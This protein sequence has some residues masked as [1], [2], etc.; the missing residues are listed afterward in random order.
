MKKS[1]IIKEM[2]S[3]IKRN[4]IPERSNEE[5]S[6][7]A[8]ELIEKMT[9]GEKLG[10][11]YET[12]YTG[13]DITGPEFNTD[14]VLNSIREGKV[15]SLLG[16]NDNVDMYI[17]QK[18]A[19]E[20]SRLGI[21]MFFANDI[22]HGC[23]TSYPVNLALASSF[24]MSLIKESYKNIAYE[25]SHSG[26][27]LT[28]APMLD[29]A[30]D[31]RWG[32]VMEGY[33]EDT[34]LGSCV[35]KAVVE[36]LQQNDLTSYDTVASCAKHFVGYAACE[37]GR[38]YNT[39]DF[40]ERMLKQYYLPPFKSAI[41]S[42]VTSIM[43]AFNIYDGIPATQNKYLL[44]KVLRDELGF[45]G[46]TISDYTSTDETI[47]HKTNKDKRSVA[48]SCMKAGLNHEMISTT[49]IDE[50][51]K[52]IE[53]GEIELEL[54]DEAVLKVLEF[55]FKIG[56]FDNPYKNI[57]HNQEDYQLNEEI[58]NHSREAS[59]RSITLLKNHN[60][61]L[62]IKNKDLKIAVIGPMGDSNEVVGPWGGRARNEDCVSLLDG[63][64][65]KNLNNISFAK[66]CKSV[67]EG[68]ESLL[69][70]AI[71]VAN[72]SDLV[73]LALGESQ[74]MS[75]EAK[76]R[77]SILIPKPQLELAN[78]IKK[79]GKKTVLVSFSGRPLDL[80][81]FDENVDGI[82]HSWF[83]GTTS[84]DAL[85]D[86]IFGDYN[87]SA[88]VSMSFPRNVGQVPIYY[89]GFKTGRPYPM[90]PN[91]VYFSNYIDS[92]NTPL[93]PFGFGLSYT[94]FEISNFE[95][96]KQELKVNEELTVKLTVKNTG[97]VKGEEVVQL[98]IEALT[99]SVT[100]P[101]NELKAFVKVCLEP[102]EEQ[103]VV[104]K[105]TTKDLAYYNEDMEFT[106][107]KTDY[108]I[109]VGNASNNLVEKLIKTV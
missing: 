100:R 54:V 102:K 15:G 3:A 41:D 51:P 76:S 14:N 34:Y 16:L 28:F 63:L 73:I 82:L 8:L 31:P 79:L 86:V 108:A 83:L 66:G 26:V 97:L 94:T 2:Q 85:A 24:D 46:F 109:R 5:V 9:L 6:K 35:A 1:E 18:L 71:K 12:T 59:K 105:L 38:D 43:S 52:L 37:G 39:V 49:Y 4:P 45:T 10:Q 53:D 47:F 80:T 62:P 50:L 68:S 88:K 72:E 89:N 40:S 92:E 44:R 36:G 84:G 30:R 91:G 107:E 7:L 19:V 32:R 103:E 87:P 70:E 29:L 56:L 42:G 55:K 58:V 81:W 25:S 98:Y 78:V 33:G 96:D 23:T 20:E 21:P 27:N 104:F 90:D 75:G 93:Y 11:L 101:L 95:I 13:A 64:T 22:I 74:D 106:A 48:K 67:N 57:Y 99:F 17:L 77:T 60:Q 69:D 61:A 65:K